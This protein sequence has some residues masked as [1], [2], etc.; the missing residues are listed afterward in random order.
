VNHL[1]AESLESVSELTV[2]LHCLGFPEISEE[3]VSSAS[4][5]TLLQGDFRVHRDPTYRPRRC[6]TSTA[7]ADALQMTRYQIITGYHGTGHITLFVGA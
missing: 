4:S 6:G 1:R 3:A 5:L 7:A 2:C